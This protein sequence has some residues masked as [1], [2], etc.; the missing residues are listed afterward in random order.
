M[1][2]TVRPQVGVPTPLMMYRAVH[3]GLGA[4]L[5][6]SVLA[7]QSPQ[8]VRLADEPAFSMAIWLLTPMELR[9]TARIRAL[10]EAFTEGARQ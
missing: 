7:E 8:L 5:V 1:H 4:G 9:Q 2:P 6:P 3:A 10:F